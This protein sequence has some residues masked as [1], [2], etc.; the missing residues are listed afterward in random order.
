MANDI[1]ISETQQQMLEDAITRRNLIVEFTSKVLKEGIERDYGIVPGTSKKTLLKPGAEKLA[2]LFGLTPTFDI[3]ESEKDWTGKYHDGE[4]FFYFLTKCKLWR[5]DSLIA[6][7]RGACTSWESKY[8]Y[9]Q[10]NRVCPLCKQETIFKS[11][12]KAGQPQTGREGWFCWKNKG[13]CGAQ[14]QSGDQSI[15]SQDA[16]RVANQDVADQLNTILKMADKRAFIAA[17]LIGVNA[18]E[19]FTQDMEDS[20]ITVAWRE[21]EPEPTHPP[22]RQA[23]PPLSN[24]VVLK[25][26]IMGHYQRVLGITSPDAIK[27]RLASHFKAAHGKPIEDATEAELQAVLE[28]IARKPDYVAPFKTEVVV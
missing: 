9:R 6:E 28:S 7:G 5:G 19:F 25:E 16:G 10:A 18:S 20:Y 13:G 2:N 14:F 8:R 24:L 12:P 22:L 11:K 27:H 17:I 3:I 21:I 26:S 1:I 4:P 15:E 23:G